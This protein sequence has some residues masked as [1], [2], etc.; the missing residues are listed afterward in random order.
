MNN[1]EKQNGHKQKVASLIAFIVISVTVTGYF[2]GLQSPMNPDESTSEPHSEVTLDE[3]VTKV[4]RP[5]SDKVIPATSYSEMGEVTGHRNLLAVSSSKM[6]TDS[7]A[8]MS[9]L[10]SHVIN[11]L[12]SVIDPLAEVKINPQDKQI[13]LEKRDRNRAFN[14]APPTIPHAIDQRS[15]RSCI[16]C[17]GKGAKTISL[18]IPRMSHQFLANCTQCH[19]ENSPVHMPA[20]LFKE[21]SFSGLAAPTSGPR[22]FKGAPPQIPHSTW[23]RTDCMSCH[24]YAGLQGIRTTHPW[25]KNCTQC[26]TPSAKMDQTLL[27]S[28]QLFLPPP[29]I[30]K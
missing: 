4:S 9:Q 29:Q 8:E 28:K 23:M 30:E 6:I 7:T 14:G 19:V 20:S 21:N 3:N 25:R 15:D 5:V 27:S 11:E 24:G 13:A 2:T 16:A 17:H 10:S 1:G 12:Q 26:H 18:R 22:A